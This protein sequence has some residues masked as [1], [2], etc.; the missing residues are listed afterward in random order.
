[1]E[2]V[3]ITGLPEVVP[4]DSLGT[5]IARALSRLSF[6]LR[7]ADVLAVAQKI[8][9]KAENRLVRLDTMIPCESAIETARELGNRDPRL[10]ELVLRESRRI[11]RMGHGVLIVETHHG[12]I[13]A[14][15]GVDLS[16]VDGGNTASLLP[17]NPDASAARI[18][19]EVRAVTGVD[20]PVLIA[21]TF[22]RPWREGLVDVAI[23][24]HGMSPLRDHR[25]Q[26]DAYGY[27]LR[28]T[29]MAEADQLAAAAG[30]VFRKNGR[31]PACLIRGFEFQPGS[32]NAS[33]LLRNPEHDLFR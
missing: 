3:P 2:L 6:T 29:V 24:V 1:M 5:L 33:D 4:G 16:N 19:S 23:G 15:A 26:T 20:V 7:S 27:Q 17:V 8:V 30:L 13:C 12:L 22:G 31:I 21:D 18:A 9:S 28:A 10:I 32:G 25:R 14:N 11:V